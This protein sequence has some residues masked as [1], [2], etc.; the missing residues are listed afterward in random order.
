MRLSLLILSIC[1][2]FSWT[3]EA[4]SRKQASLDQAYRYLEDQYPMGRIPGS[5]LAIVLG[6]ATIYQGYR[7]S[8]S[9]TGTSGLEGVAGTAQFL[10]GSIMGLDGI[11]R[12]T[13]SNAMEH[14][15]P[16]YLNMKEGEK[17][18]IKG[19]RF[20]YGAYSLKYYGEGASRVR[21]RRAILDFLT[22]ATFF[23]QVLDA[24]KDRFVEIEG[25]RFEVDKRKVFNSIPPLYPALLFTGLG[26]YRLLTSY[27]EERAWGKYRDAVQSSSVEFYASALPNGG[28]AGFRLPL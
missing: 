6:G 19:N 3:L 26:I 28:Y 23:L 24:S 13:T 12:I 11:I 18:P 15:A 21:W 7:L 9:E 27:P 1:F 4:K 5:V 10:L 25:Q 14:I 16:Y 2:V 22:A 17:P 20:S 8:I